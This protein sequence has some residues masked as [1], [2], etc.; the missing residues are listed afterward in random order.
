MPELTQLESAK[1]M[2]RYLPANGTASFARL[3]DSTDRRS[4]CPPARMTATTLTPTS[5]SPAPCSALGGVCPRA[6]P[7]PGQVWPP[8]YGR[9][10]Q[11]VLSCV[12]TAHRTQIAR[13]SHPTETASKDVEEHAVQLPEQPR[14]LDVEADRSRRAVRHHVVEQVELGVLL[15]VAGRDQRR[16]PPRLRVRYEAVAAV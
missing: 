8:H 11:R 4:P 1:S 12:H 16:H 7:G 14:K 13:H 10:R 2:I 3:T 5:S 15:Q 6:R 9:P